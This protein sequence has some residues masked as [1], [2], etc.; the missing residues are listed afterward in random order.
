[1]IAQSGHYRDGDSFKRVFMAH[2]SSVYKAVIGSMMT[3]MLQFTY[4]LT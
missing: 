2:L 4:L 3:M 1:M